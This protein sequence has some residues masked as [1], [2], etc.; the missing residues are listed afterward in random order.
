MLDDPGEDELSSE[1][2]AT[3]KGLRAAGRTRLIGVGGKGSAMDAYISMGGFDA[4]ALPYNLACGWTE[5]LRLKAAAERDMAVIGY[6]FWPQEFHQPQASKLGKAVKRLFWTKAKTEEA[7]AAI[8]TYAFLYD[9]PGWTAE[10][11]CLAYAL[12]E[13]S[14]ATVQ[15]PTSSIGRLTELAEITER[16]MPAGVASRIEMARFGGHRA[17]G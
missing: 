12:T 10:D 15:I 1:A 5:R 14:I 2:M 13:P 6:D 7:L 8:G 11:I 17:A 16:E 3:M 9:T 4:I